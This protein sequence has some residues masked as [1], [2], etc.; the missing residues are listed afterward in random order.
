MDYDGFKL[1]I[2]RDYE[3][4]I[5]QDKASKTKSL[6]ELRTIYNDWHTKMLESQE[7]YGFAN[8][9]TGDKD[10]SLFMAKTTYFYYL[11]MFGWTSLRN[12]TDKLRKEHEEL[13]KQSKPKRT[14]SKKAK[15]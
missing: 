5:E 6:E 8:D 10:L 11:A 15:T 7:K 13:K 9:T 12:Y 3:K 4:F 14:K 1:L 2:D